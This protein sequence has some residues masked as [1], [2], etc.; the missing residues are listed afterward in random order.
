MAQVSSSVVGVP[1]EKVPRGVMVLG[2]VAAVVALGF[3]IM[4]P[5]IPLFAQE[6]GVGKTA[7]GLAISAFAFFRFVS[8]FASGGLVDRFGERR[9]LTIGLTVVAVTSAMAALAPTYPWFVALRGVGGI[10]SAAF[11]VAAVSLVLRLS[12]PHLRARST[13]TFQAGF[14][15]GGVAG[16]A[17]G[18]PLTDL[19]P[20]LPFFVYGAALLIAAGVALVGL[21]SERQVPTRGLEQGPDGAADIPLRV[22]LRHP[23]YIAALVVNLGVGWMLFGVRNSLVPLYVIEDLQQTAT[24][25][26]LGFLVG[27]AAQALG[28]LRSGRLADTLGRRPAMIIGTSLATA[29]I[30][31]LVLPPNLVL[32]IV[33]MAGFG[34]GAAFLGSAPSAVV[35]DLSPA[36][37]GRMV[38]VFQMAS[39][40]GAVAGPLTAG[41]LADRFSTPVAFGATAGVLAL[42]LVAALLMPETRPRGPAPSAPRK[43]P[44]K[45]ESAQESAQDAA[46]ELGGSSGKVLPQ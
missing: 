45:D 33:A 37:G 13:N 23:A 17:I 34:L 6:Y 40:V 36:K 27:S 39:D 35:G 12:P 19:D 15:L 11:T 8:A 26:G 44:S 10:G 30:A 18:G 43:E 42:G 3:G 32:F 38:A 14:L 31:L 21:P 24:F 16:P 9:V 20:R 22:V 7:V 41:Y 25:A 29:S 46:C 1:R 5:A 4:A 28:V 2:V